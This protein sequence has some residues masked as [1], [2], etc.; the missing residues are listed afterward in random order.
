MNKKQLFI[1]TVAVALSVS[2]AF[3]VSDITGVTGN[4]GIYNITPE[5]VNSDVGYRKYDNFTLGEGDIANLIYK[6]GTSK[7][8]E[9]FVNL[10]QNGVNI[11]VS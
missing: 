4:N 5:K 8:I 10:V 7:D 6:Y 1:A 3:A 2:S 9:T 11:K